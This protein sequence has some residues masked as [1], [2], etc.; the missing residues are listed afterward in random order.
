M[1]ILAV[2]ALSVLS[3]TLVPAQTPVLETQRLSDR[4]LFIQGP[5]ANVLAVES[6]EGI[7]L[8]DGG[9]AHWYDG[10]R[11][12]LDEHFPGTPVRA[13]FNTHWHPEQTGAN[14]PLAKEGAEIIAHENTM[15][16]LSTEIRQRWSGRVYKPLP[17]EAL[18]T[19]T[20][21]DDGTIKLGDRIVHYG[22]MMNAHTDGDIWV[23]FEEENV[24]VTGGPVSNGRWPE[25]DWWTGGYIG[26]LLDGFVSLLTV[27]DKDTRIIPAYGDIMSREELEAQNQMYLTIF[28]RLHGMLIDSNSLEEVLKAGLTAEYDTRMGDPTKFLTLAFSSFQGRLR[29]PQNFRILNI[30]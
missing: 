3:S 7:I 14:V 4:M 27:P 30:P 15:L 9:H 16:W 6:S 21:F 19:T 17:R 12:S 8:V 11:R 10:L 28:D 24:L 29:D 23:Y 1:A 22:Y 5:D 2:M 20:V 18:P 25:I 26:G 13:L